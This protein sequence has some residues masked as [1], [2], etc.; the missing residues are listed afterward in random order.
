AIGAEAVSQPGGRR[1]ERAG[2]NI[3]SGRKEAISD[4][5][6]TDGEWTR[7]EIAA[8]VQIVNRK[9]DVIRAIHRGAVVVKPSLVCEG[10]ALSAVVA[11]A[12]QQSH[13]GNY[14]NTNFH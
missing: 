12:C 4:S 8:G 2:P 13:C 11:N 10:G 6:G 3:D 1:R 9:T 7:Y 5:D 14:H